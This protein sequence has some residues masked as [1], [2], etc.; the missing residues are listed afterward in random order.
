MLKDCVHL[1]KA[2]NKNPQYFSHHPVYMI[3]PDTCKIF[4]QTSLLFIGHFGGLL[5]AH[6][7]KQINRKGLG[8][9]PSEAERGKG[10]SHRKQTHRHVCKYIHFPLRR[11]V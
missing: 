6:S 10:S 8:V 1:V 7:Q 2:K 5:C 3:K 9:T 11:A 4:A